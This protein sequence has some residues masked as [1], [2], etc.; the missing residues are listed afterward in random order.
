ML[1]LFSISY[2][3]VPTPSQGVSL[4]YRFSLVL[5]SQQFQNIWHFPLNAV[6]FK[7]NLKGEL[8]SK[9]KLGSC[10]R[11]QKIRKEAF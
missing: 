5:I 2:S 9:N 4:F 11:A 6:I 7:S 1:S 8:T 10:E 3:F